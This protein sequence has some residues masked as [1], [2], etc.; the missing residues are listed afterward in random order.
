MTGMARWSAGRLVA[1]CALAVLI[2]AVVA[3]PCLLV[4]STGIGIPTADQLSYRLEIVLVASLVGAGLS[5]AGVAYQ[6]VLRNP[7]AEPY[8][9]GVSSGAALAAYAWR[10][11]NISWI[12]ITVGAVS[13]QAFAFA[14]AVVS[15]AVVFALASRRGRME[16]VTLLLVGVIVNSVNGALFLLINVIRKDEGSILPFLVGAIQTSL[17]ANQRVTALVVIGAMW[18]VLLALAGKLN[19]ASLSDDEAAALGVNVN[20]LRW[21][22]L[23]AASLMTASAVSISG[24]IGFVGLICPHVTRWLVGSDKRRLLPI[25]TA[26]G[27]GVL[28][29]ADAATRGMALSPNIQTIL[30]VGVVTALIGGPF[31]LAI[32]WRARHRSERI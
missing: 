6:A 32:L 28:C 8:L 10:S 30:P 7:L 24:P 21:L 22:T 23:G 9:L 29:V 4:G 17:T 15:I 3:A 5:A 16:P 1:T 13:Q 20:R 2:W 14:G 11:F 12:A 18:L 31:F 26:V 19:T 27:A 25:A